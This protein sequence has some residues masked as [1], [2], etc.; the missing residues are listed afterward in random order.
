M[1]NYIKRRFMQLSKAL[2]ISEREVESDQVELCGQCDA[3]GNQDN[4]ETE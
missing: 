2:V 4:L 1:G 3:C